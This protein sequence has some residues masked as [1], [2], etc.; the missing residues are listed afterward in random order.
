MSPF[1]FSRVSGL[2]AA[3]QPSCLASHPAPCDVENEKRKEKSDGNGQGQSFNR[4]VQVQ[5]STAWCLCV[6]KEQTWQPFQKIIKNWQHAAEVMMSLPS[7]LYQPERNTLKPYGLWSLNSNLTHQPPHVQGVSDCLN[8]SGCQS[9]FRGTDMQSK[10]CM[11]MPGKQRK[12][13]A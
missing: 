10:I 12:F 8:P 5:K 9:S 3:T 13:S 11:F 6:V 1:L 4:L 2:M 7:L